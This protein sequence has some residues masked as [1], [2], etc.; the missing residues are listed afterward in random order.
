MRAM[1]L[2]GVAS[3]VLLAGCGQSDEEMVEQTVRASMT[4]LAAG[5]GPAACAHM[6][7]A[8]QE[9]FG[10]ILG[11]FVGD[12]PRERTCTEAVDE[13]GKSNDGKLSEAA[14]HVVHGGTATARPD[15]GPELI[16]LAREN[17][18]WKITAKIGRAS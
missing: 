5:D 16:R 11:Y 12:R 6:T 2:V 14:V 18:D 1:L 3:A 9:E 8:G 4:A 15:G 10:T 7:P 17:D 13:F